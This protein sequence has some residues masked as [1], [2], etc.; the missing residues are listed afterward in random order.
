MTCAANRPRN[1]LPGNPVPGVGRGVRRVVGGGTGFARRT[2][3]AARNA[4]RVRPERH[5]L[6]LRRL[7][8]SILRSIETK[9]IALDCHAVAVVDHDAWPSTAGDLAVTDRAGLL[10]GWRPDGITEV[11]A[12]TRPS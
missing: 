2:V 11:G 7:G 10:A 4:E 12:N 3:L 9:L 6:R 5:T 1:P 8:H